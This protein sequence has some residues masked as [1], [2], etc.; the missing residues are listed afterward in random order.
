MPDVFVYGTLT[1]PDRVAEI[2]ESFVYVGPA[3]LE[4]LH[5]VSGRYPTLAPGGQTA[6][7]LLRTDEI[8]RLDA[9]EGV[10]RGLYVRRSVPRADDDTVEL[11]V[12]NPDRF[13]ADVEWP[14]DGPFADR[15]DAYLANTD[16]RV[17]SPP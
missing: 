7:R 2:L 11:Y 8:D 15:V 4:G 9:Y 12:G 6:G 14:G 10:D 3:R 13:D 5:V 17:V 1:E 16:V